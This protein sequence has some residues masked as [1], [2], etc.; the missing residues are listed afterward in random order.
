METGIGRSIGIGGNTGGIIG[1]GVNPTNYSIKRDETK[2]LEEQLSNYEDSFSESKPT[3][4]FGQTADSQI[5]S[6]N[7]DTF[8]MSEETQKKMIQI[9]GSEGND[10]IKASIN[11][12]NG[13]IV[14]NINGEIREYTP[15]EAAN[16]FK[17]NLGDGNDS[18]DISAIS[19]NIVIDAGEGNN[20]IN[21][22]QGR[23]FVTAGNGNNS[24]TSTE[25]HL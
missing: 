17:I 5:I 4:M 20:D 3:M 6:D 9:N 11:E 7:I 10:V 18:V 19:N 21:L 25:S 8:V 24:I 2:T 16:G 1:G 14:I 23:N 12:E 15:E 22:S 13:N